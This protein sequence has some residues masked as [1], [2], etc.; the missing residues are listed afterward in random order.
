MDRLDLAEIRARLQTI[1]EVQ[2]RPAR[3]PRFEL[4][5]LWRGRGSSSASPPQPSFPAP[6]RVG[7]RSEPVLE[8]EPELL[9]EVPLELT[10]P[11]DPKVDDD[12]AGRR[13]A[14]GQ[15]REP[16]PKPRELIAAP[17]PLA[18]MD[19]DVGEAL[20]RLGSS[21]T[22]A[23]LVPLE[24]PDLPDDFD[25]ARPA[26]PVPPRHLILR[27]TEAEIAPAPI[28]PE[29]ELLQHLERVFL[30]EHAGLEAHR[31]SA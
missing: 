6:R 25:G 30:A 8:S 21:L 24:T 20:R 28:N 14:F 2:G 13:N 23:S 19:E 26:P 15:R 7:L 5:G 11:L 18:V 10:A 27:R 3:K 29:A 9:L 31:L 1:V 17:P 16:A 12:A 22:R 4:A